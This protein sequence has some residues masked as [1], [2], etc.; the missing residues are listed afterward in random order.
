MVLSTILQPAY[1][2][3]FGQCSIPGEEFHV[4]SMKEVEPRNSWVSIRMCKMGLTG[5][6]DS[7][8][9]VLAVLIVLLARV[10]LLRNVL[11]CMTRLVV[12]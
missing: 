5:L 4:N 6:R 8:V 1:L 10:Y 7:Y 3:A 9:R 12:P 11:S 2:P